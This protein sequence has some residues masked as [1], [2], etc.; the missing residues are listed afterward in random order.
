MANKFQAIS[1]K[2]FL[3]AKALFELI[4]LKMRLQIFKQSSG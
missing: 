1:K 2:A 3:T 4:C